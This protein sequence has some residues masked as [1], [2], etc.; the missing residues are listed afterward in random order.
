MIKRI[1]NKTPDNILPYV[2][3]I[4]TNNNIIPTANICFKTFK[5]SFISLFI[6][7]VENFEIFQCSPNEEYSTYNNG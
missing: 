4:T 7:W 6:L 3:V 5:T 1:V 2:N